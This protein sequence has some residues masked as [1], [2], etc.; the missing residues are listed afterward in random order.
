M[1]SIVNF[2]K[3]ATDNNA[4]MLNATTQHKFSCDIGIYGMCE[5][6][7]GGVQLYQRVFPNCWI[8]LELLGSTYIYIYPFLSIKLICQRWSQYFKHKFSLKQQRHCYLICSTENPG[9]EFPS[10]HPNLVF[11]RFT[12]RVQANIY[13]NIAQEKTEGGFVSI[14]LMEASK[15][16]FAYILLL[17]FV[18]LLGKYSDNSVQLAGIRSRFLNVIFSQTNTETG[19]RIQTF[20]F[21]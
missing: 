21:H 8:F 16:S 13:E 14:L 10:D 15:T 18:S 11:I 12:K 20:Y 7:S 6:P 19:L 1:Y 17:S 4:K 3:D 9:L 2:A 5:V